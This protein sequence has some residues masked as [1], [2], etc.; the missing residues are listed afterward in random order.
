MKATFFARKENYQDKKWEVVDARGQVVGR[1]AARISRI[2]TGKDKTDYTP[3]VETGRGVVV[4]NAAHITVTGNKAKAKIYKHYSGYPSGQRE[5]TFEEVMKK[6][7]TYPLK[8]AVKGMLPKSPLGYRMITRLLVYPGSEHP[9]QAQVF[10]GTSK[11]KV[12]KEKKS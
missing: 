10:S 12:K 8:H 1:L 11:I 4:I 3:H 6:D 2:L 5:D 7:P 9:H